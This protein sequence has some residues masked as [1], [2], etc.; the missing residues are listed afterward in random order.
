[1][2]SYGWPIHIYLNPVQG[3]FSLIVNTRC[4][5]CCASCQEPHFEGNRCFPNQAAIKAMTGVRDEDIIT[6]S[7][8][9]AVHIVPFYVVKVE[10]NGQNE[11]IIAIRGTLSI[12][13]CAITKVIQTTCSLYNN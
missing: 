11:V 5:C 9:N 1:M 7:F 8:V 2:A 12:K 4:N 13:V 6:A 3:P 10:R